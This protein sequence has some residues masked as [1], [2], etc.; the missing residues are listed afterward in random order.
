MKIFVIF[1]FAKS[2]I[3]L[4]FIT[5]LLLPLVTIA[6]QLEP[7]FIYSDSITGKSISLDDVWKYHAGDDS[8]WANPDFVDTN[9]DKLKTRMTVQTLRKIFG[10][11][12]VGLE[13]IY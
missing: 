11:E 6:Q 13:Q 2:L 8:V 10:R 5:V 4:S 12:L 1:F 9:W 3:R 7:V